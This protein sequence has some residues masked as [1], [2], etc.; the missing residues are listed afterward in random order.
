MENTNIKN[1]TPLEKFAYLMDKD[2]YIIENKIFIDM[3]WNISKNISSNPK[4]ST[5]RNASIMLQHVFYWHFNAIKKGVSTTYQYKGKNTIKMDFEDWWNSCR[6]T[7]RE[8]TTANKFLKE[9]KLIE[10]VKMRI[11]VKDS[12]IFKPSNCYILNQDKI[13]EYLNKIIEI[14]KALYTEKVIDVRKKN[15]ETSKKSRDIDELSTEKCVTT[16]SEVTT[17]TNGL[18]VIDEKLSTLSTGNTCGKSIECNSVTTQSEVTIVTPQSEVTNKSNTTSDTTY[19]DSNNF[20]NPSNSINKLELL[21]LLKSNL[22]DVSFKTW[23]VSGIQN[24][25][26]N[27]NTLEITAINNF[28]K[29]ILENRYLDLLKKCINNMGLT[30]SKI[31]IK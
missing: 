30:K 8:V 12:D 14:N 2:N 22:S 18:N 29:E 27:R 24:L 6:L 15:N 7:D 13:E 25:E 23:F 31:I 19:T 20:S 4:S 1:K 28:V 26:F 11:K 21:E 5:I 9:T 3:M 16:Q 10:I 17:N